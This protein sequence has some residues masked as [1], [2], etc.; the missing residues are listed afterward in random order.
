VYCVLDSNSSLGFRRKLAKRNYRIFR[1]CAAPHCAADKNNS[2]TNR[3]QGEARFGDL[4]FTADG[5]NRNSATIR[6]GKIEVRK[7]DSSLV[8]ISGFEA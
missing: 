4:D 6:T 7:L 1:A 8:R 2:N 5:A 3:G